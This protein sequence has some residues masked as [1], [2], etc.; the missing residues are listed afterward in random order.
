MS[1][2]KVPPTRLSNMS[3]KIIKSIL[4]FYFLACPSLPRQLE[5]D[6]DNCH[7]KHRHTDKDCGELQ[8]V[9]TEVQECSWTGKTTVALM[10]WE[11]EFFDDFY[12]KDCPDCEC[13]HI[14]FFDGRDSSSE[15]LGRFCGS[16]PPEG[17]VTSG[18]YVSFT[19]KAGN[20]SKIHLKYKAT[21]SG[22][23]Y[24]IIQ[25]YLQS[26]LDILFQDRS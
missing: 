13:E 6:T 22:G 7:P 23:E 15:S 10:R 14:E 2:R 1:H 21:Y 18:K 25:P 3:H 12:F 17:L 8:E 19:I 24:L 16:T 20:T 9:F 11:F 4:T 5:G 26:I